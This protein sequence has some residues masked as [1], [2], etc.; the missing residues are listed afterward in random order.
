MVNCSF[1]ARDTTSLGDGMFLSKLTV[2]AHSITCLL[3]SRYKKQGPPK[4]QNV[5]REIGNTEKE[6]HLNLLTE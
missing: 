1:M 6:V 3:F 5:I 2:D 4:P